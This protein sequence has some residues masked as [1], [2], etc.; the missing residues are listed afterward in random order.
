MRKLEASLLGAP[1]QV[2]CLEAEF[3]PVGCGQAV[4][5]TDRLGV[6]FGSRPTSRARVP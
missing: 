4:S 2:F 5:A 6:D 1:K 3:Y